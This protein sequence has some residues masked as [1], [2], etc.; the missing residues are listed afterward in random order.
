[1]T[2]TNDDRKILELESQV[3]ELAER[4]RILTD[5]IEQLEATAFQLVD[6]EEEVLLITV[7]KKN[8]ERT[9]RQKLWR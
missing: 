8:D 2:E 1:M 5:R 3:K 7:P 9:L 4:V 6:D